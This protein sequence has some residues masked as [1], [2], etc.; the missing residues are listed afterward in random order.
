MLS[1]KELKHLHILSRADSLAEAAH[2]AGLTASAISQSLTGIEQKLGTQLFV[3]RKGALHMTPAGRTVLVRIE[4]ALN[5]LD[6]LQND[7]DAMAEGNRASVRFGVGHAVASLLLPD[8]LKCLHR[9]SP[10]VTPRFLVKFWDDCEDRLLRGDIDL[11]VGGFPSPP[12]DHRFDFELLYTDRVI[13][14]ARGDHPIFA[15]EE[16]TIHDVIRYPVLAHDS[17]YYM[18]WRNLDSVDDL[19]LFNRNVPASVVPDP[20]AML[21]LVE[22]TN[23]IVFTTEYNWLERARQHRNLKVVP[24]KSLY[25]TA[26]MMFVKNAGQQLPEAYQLLIKCFKQAW[27]HTGLARVRD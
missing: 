11:F 13:A 15:R 22:T 9:A 16:C 6:C 4:R 5:E 23:H 24:M 10:G 19:D 1:I 20:L 25:G 18:M 7:I 14:I 27:R 3:R 2:R 8:T 21:P 26:H 12:D 17:R